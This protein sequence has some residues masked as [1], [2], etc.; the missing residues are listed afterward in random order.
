MP[1]PSRPITRLRKLCLAL[2]QAVETFPFDPELSVFRTGGNAK[3][4]ALVYLGE[5]YATDL[6]GGALLAEMVRTL[7]PR[8]GPRLLSAAAHLEALRG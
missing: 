2:P 4:F 3:I 8:L 6:V 5:H 7:A 1:P